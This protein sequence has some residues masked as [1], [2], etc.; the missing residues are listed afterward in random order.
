[1]TLASTTWF[2]MRTITE[3]DADTVRLTMARKLHC[4]GNNEHQ[5]LMVWLEENGRPFP[6]ARTLRLAE[7]MQ[8]H[9]REVRFNRRGCS[10]SESNLQ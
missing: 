5:G 4:T 7:Q 6:P 1:M 3:A 2:S 9:G 8:V 10:T